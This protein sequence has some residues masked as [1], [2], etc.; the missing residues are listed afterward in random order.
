VRLGCGGCLTTVVVLGV[1]AGAMAWVVWLITG[2][3]AAPNL[4][5]IAI[6]DETR[7]AQKLAQITRVG[8]GRSPRQ[9]VETINLTEGELNAL[10]ARRLAGLAELP[11]SRVQLRL[12]GGGQA[13]IA[14]QVPLAAVLTERPVSR[15]ASLVPAGWQR[16]PIWLRFRL[17]A[18]LDSTDEGR[19]RY[20]RL[21][22][23]R[24]WVGQRRLPSVLP[25]LMLS[26]ATLSVLHLRLPDTVRDVVIEVGRVDVTMA[27]SP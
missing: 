16:T 11:L 25:R 6:G 26:P 13:E 24:F 7:A 5:E 8:R 10:L 15:L 21:D 12:P 14:G 1:I 18:R 23:E 27:A 4:P 22:I 19:R 20:L 17:Q 9:A 2:V 3:L